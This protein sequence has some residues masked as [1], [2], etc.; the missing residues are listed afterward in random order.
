MS[1]SS[2]YGTIV[3]F[4]LFYVT[5][6]LYCVTPVLMSRY[7]LTLSFIFSLVGFDD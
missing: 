6:V 5:S 2:A 1:V 4:D 7:S 3:S